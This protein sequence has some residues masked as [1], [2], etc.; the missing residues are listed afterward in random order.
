MAGT[1][2]ASP[3]RQNQDFAGIIFCEIQQ[4]LVQFGVRLIPKS[5]QCFR[6]VVGCKNN[7]I[8]PQIGDI[9]HFESL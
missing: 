1:E 8:A 3:T 4:Y 7:A 2:G 5:V 9:G 6:P